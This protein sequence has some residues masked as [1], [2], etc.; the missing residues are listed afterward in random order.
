MTKLRDLREELGY[1]K[2]QMAAALEMPYTTYV[3]YEKGERGLSSET[4]KRLS[5]FFGVSTDYILGRTENREKDLTPPG[6][7]NDDNLALREMLR[8]RPDVKILFDASKDA[9][10][11]AILEAA[12]LIMRYK[13]ESERE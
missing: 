9:P 8:T 12:A 10:T 11:S 3:S 7:E 13:E 2:K 5:N 4:L 1:N 6:L